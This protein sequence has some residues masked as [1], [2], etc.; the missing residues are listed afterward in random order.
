MRRPKPFVETLHAAVQ[1]V[2][3]VVLRQPVFHAVQLEP[4]LG[5]AIGVAA[6]QR[7]EEGIVAQIA[8]EIVEPE[9]HICH[10]PV[11]VGHENRNHPATVV[12]N[13]H[14]HAASV[15]KRVEIHGTLRYFSVSAPPDACRGLRRGRAECACNAYQNQ[16]T[17]T[18][19]RPKA[20]HSFPFRSCHGR[21]E[22]RS[23]PQ[24]LIA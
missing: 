11:P 19:Q 15:R 4:G 13:P 14:F 1:A 9:N 5:D 21:S 10:F 23:R 18:G 12:R 16:A 22:W 7:A 17:P 2:G 3:S 6:D 24:R 8:V 20:R